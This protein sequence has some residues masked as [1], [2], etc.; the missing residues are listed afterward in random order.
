ML[1]FGSTEVTG[2]TRLN[3]PYH[4]AAGAGFTDVGWNRVERADIPT[5]LVYSNGTAATGVTVNLGVAPAS[6]ATTW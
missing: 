3:S 5:G 4:T 2:D 1:D 6:G